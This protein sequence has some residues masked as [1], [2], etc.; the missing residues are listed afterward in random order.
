MGCRVWGILSPPA[1]YA[2]HNLQQERSPV[3]R[4]CLS[5]ANID[6]PCGRALLAVGQTATALATRTGCRHGHVVVGQHAVHAGESVPV[7]KWNSSQ[8]HFL[9]MLLLGHQMMMVGLWLS[10]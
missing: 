5:L 6:S 2:P 4:P 10:S 8:F 7:Q 9:Q 3:V 1:G